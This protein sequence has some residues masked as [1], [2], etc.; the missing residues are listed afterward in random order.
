MARDA[1]GNDPQAAR[2]VTTSKILIAPYKSGTEL[3]ATM[4]APTVTDPIT[5]GL[6]SVFTDAA[7]CA[8]GLI[9][10]DGAPQD[11]R[12][13]GD[14]IEFHQPGYLLPGDPTLTLQFTAAE[15]NDL[16][17]SLT[18]GKPDSTGVYHVADTVQSE[19]FIAYQ[20]TVYRNGKIRRR[21]GVFQPTAAEPAQ[22]TRGSV[23]GVS[24][25]GQW[26]KDSICD[27]VLTA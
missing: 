14:S 10:S 26:M 19:K 23:D 21:L 16:V 27:R 8:V 7:K 18:I 24:I 9:T 22:D 2:V 3:T 5:T 20:E 17:K 4:I 15:D 12:D 13:S 1:Q 11:G 25:T 6:K